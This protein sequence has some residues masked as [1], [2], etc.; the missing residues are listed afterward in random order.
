MSVKVNLPIF[1][2]AFTDNKEAIDTEGST[3]S[4]CIDALIRQYPEVKKML[5]DRKGNL[6]SYVGIYINSQDAFPNVMEKPVKDGDEI[7]ILYSLA[8]G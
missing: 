1:L 6:H 5:I 8:G 2:Q 3:V 7:H 4:E